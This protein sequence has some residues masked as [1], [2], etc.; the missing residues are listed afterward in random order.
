V[1]RFTSIPLSGEDLRALIS[2]ATTVDSVTGPP[3]A[4]FAQSLLLPSTA[5]NSG[6]KFVDLSYNPFYMYGKGHQMIG[7]EF[8]I[9]A[10]ESRWLPDSAKLSK[11][12]IAA[13][14]ATDI[15]LKATLINRVSET[16]DNNLSFSVDVGYIERRLGGDASDTPAFVRAALGDSTRTRFAGWAIGTYLRLRQVTAFADF[17]C[18]SCKP[19]WG[20]RSG[21]KIESLEGL[22]PVIGFRFEAPFFS[23]ADK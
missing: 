16:D 11:A 4:S 23:L 3:G 22:Q 10:A 1:G 8:R 2:V 17:Q 18:L 7:P 12:K 6:W 19:F 20:R 15:R 13:L 5:P 14:V 9:V 21:T